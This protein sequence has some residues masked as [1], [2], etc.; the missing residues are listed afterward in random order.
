MPSSTP[1]TFA[2]EGEQFV[3]V[4][5]GGGNSVDILVSTLTPEIESAN[6]GVRLW[7]FKLRGK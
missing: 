5:T 1:I 2:F 7:V 3:A 6:G 4:T